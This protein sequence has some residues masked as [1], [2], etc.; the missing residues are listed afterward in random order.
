MYRINT[1]HSFPGGT[2]TLGMLL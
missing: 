1:P 2:A